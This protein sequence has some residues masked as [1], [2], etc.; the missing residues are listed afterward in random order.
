MSIRLRTVIGVRATRSI[1]LW[2][3]L[4]GIAGVTFATRYRWPLTEDAVMYALDIMRLGRVG[5]SAWPAVFNGELSF[6]YYGLL[7]QLYRFWPSPEQLATVLALVNVFSSVVVI[8]VLMYLAR[9]WF[10]CTVAFFAGLLLAL[11]PAFWQLSRY[12]HPTIPAL[13]A[14][15]GSLT[16]LDGMVGVRRASWQSAGL[17]VLLAIVAY[18]LRLDVLL[19]APT[20]LALAAWR[21]Q[22]VRRQ[23][24]WVLALWGAAVAGYGAIRLLALGYLWTPGGG[25]LL[26]HVGRTL[27]HGAAAGNVAKNLALWA[28][29]LNPFVWL[30]A[31]AAVVSGLWQ[32][33]FWP[34]LFLAV[35]LL[36]V[37]VLLP[38]YALDFS[39]IATLSA[40]AAALAAALLPVQ[41]ASRKPALGLAVFLV[42][43]QLA[44]ALIYP[45]A[46]CA[47][48]PKTVYQGRPL[49]AVP[50]GF[51][52]QDTAYRQRYLDERVRAAQQIASLRDRDV[53]IV[54][55][56]NL[57]LYR[58][59]LA[60]TRDAWE[61]ERETVTGIPIGV[62]RAAQNRF[63]LFDAD[64]CPGCERPL[65]GLVNGLHASALAVHAVPF[66]TRFP[67]QGLLLSDAELANW[68]REN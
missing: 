65:A 49:A 44:A 59:A 35:W 37:G 2:T 38:F 24:V 45:V 46:V 8:G 19:L 28:M 15:L 3:L 51:V 30:A 67:S 33:R 27:Q 68:L 11:A 53:L 18:T 12:G 7:L 50:L 22:A 10:G 20:Y 62:I 5:G 41:F 61:E 66:D 63:Y 16:L 23:L 54:G 55:A 31:M 43:A 4:T 32:R 58:L 21:G 17:F 47:Y 34:A 29:G 57:M 56:S 14:F 25:S 52:W 9:R 39:R 60:T 42:V 64:D 48:M 40:P 6:G 36:P 1:W 26:L 13:A